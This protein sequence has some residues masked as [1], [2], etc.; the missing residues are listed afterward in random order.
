LGTLNRAGYE[1]EL[2]HETLFVRRAQFASARIPRPERPVY[3]FVERNS[4][5]AP[6]PRRV[7]L[8]FANVCEK[9]WTPAV[10]PQFALQGLFDAATS[11]KYYLM[12]FRPAAVPSCGK[13]RC[14]VPDTR[15]GI[16]M[17]LNDPP[18]KIEARVCFFRHA[19]ADCGR[20]ILDRR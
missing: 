18:T 13:K 4:D 10:K 15:R 17:L 20:I 2:G 14:T 12:D 1:T 16:G 6:R 11:G 19:G 7:S 8:A 9:V 5:H 3:R